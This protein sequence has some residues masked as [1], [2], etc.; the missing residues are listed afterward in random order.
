[1]IRASVVSLILINNIL[2]KRIIYGLLTLIIPLFNKLR[3]LISFWD[4]YSAIAIIVTAVSQLLKLRGR[5]RGN[6]L[7]IK[8][9]PT[10]SAVY[11]SFVV[12]AGSNFTVTMDNK[13]KHF[14]ALAVDGN[15]KRNCYSFIVFENLIPLVAVA[16]QIYHKN[17]TW[18][19][20]IVECVSARLFFT[21]HTV[22]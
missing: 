6:F 21:D 13:R 4:L 20:N 12:P 18:R 2:N 16:L 5:N 8:F 1:M 14:V 15:F 17:V 11:I 3:M 19:F 7:V 22:I 10:S 9:I